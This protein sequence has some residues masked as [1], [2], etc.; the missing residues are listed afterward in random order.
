MAGLFGYSAPPAQLDPND[1][2]SL[3]NF[4]QM[5]APAVPQ[6]PQASLTGPDPSSLPNFSP[7]A[8][9]PQ[10]APGIAGPVPP[11]MGGIAGIGTALMA[12]PHSIIANVE[13][14]EQN[15][16]MA[17]QMRAAQF[18]NYQNMY[19]MINAMPDGDPRKMAAMSN[20]AEY[21]KALSSNYAQHTVKGGDTDVMN[22]VAQ[23]PAPIMSITDGT[24]STQYADRNVVTGDRL[25]GNAVAANGLI[26][27]PHGVGGPNNDGLLGKY[28]IPTLR[29]AGTFLENPTPDTSM[30]PKPGGG[31]I[32]PQ[33]GSPSDGP[34]PPPA[35]PP[36]GFSAR[37]A[38]P[39]VPQRDPNAPAPTPTAF[40]P[41]PRTIGTP[42]PDIVALVR[43]AY[44]EGDPTPQGWQSVAGVI[45]NRAKQSGLGPAQVVAQPGQF[46]SY[47]NRR[48]RN[49]RPGTDAFNRV[50][51]A[52]A[53]VIE[54]HD[55]T[56][57]ADSFYAPALQSRLGRPKPSWDDGSG[58]QIGTQLFFRG[59]YGGAPSAPGAPAA[60]AA[61]PG[62]PQGGYTDASGNN[63]SPGSN[64]TLASATEPHTLTPAELAAGGWPPGTVVVR[65]PDGTFSVP[66]KRA[67]AAL[68]P[69]DQAALNGVR[70]TAMKYARLAALA[71]QF[72][73]RSQGVRQG[74]LQAIPGVS[75]VEAPFDDRIANLNSLTKEMIPLQRDVGSG[76]IRIGE[77]QGPGGGIWGADV[78]DIRRGAGANSQNAQDWSDIAGQL[79]HYVAFK[80]AWATNHGSLNGSDAAWAAQNGG[81]M[82]RLGGNHQAGPPARLDPRNPA[83][84]YA[85]LP[86]GALYVDP[87][88]KTRRKG[89][90]A[91]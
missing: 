60:S 64:T 44:S 47:G 90:A 12:I 34:P 69:D 59:K 9:P 10:P 67:D 42:T 35:P 3:P 91:P 30:A 11:Q 82:F 39:I 48:F 37:P 32:V 38:G 73:Q 85:A 88:G 66:V 76:P 71:Q 50:A 15:I 74:G 28:S 56:G 33:A 8:A 36:T 72:V 70:E 80:E 21:G 4:A 57:G 77:I 84:S 26:L 16:A 75:E 18:A 83:A 29:P 86:A 19:R 54:G 22:G 62:A 49:L 25:P 27:D 63:V 61:P 55:P 7:M 68:P 65:A 2:A 89:A 23:Q 53:P 81:T 17:R 58:Q 13:A 52:I 51:A 87:T 24:P 43:A 5:Q 31:P 14:G 45:M 78:P 40:G 1:P 20:L 6:L 79:Q 41:P 46:E